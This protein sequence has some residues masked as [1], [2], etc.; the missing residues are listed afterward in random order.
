M[1]IEVTHHWSGQNRDIL[2]ESKSSS[3]AQLSG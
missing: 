2:A 3:A 1:A